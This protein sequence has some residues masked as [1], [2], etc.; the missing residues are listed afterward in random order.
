MTLLEGLLN[1]YLF[2]DQLVLTT[3]PIYTTINCLL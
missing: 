2:Y 1:L 3:L